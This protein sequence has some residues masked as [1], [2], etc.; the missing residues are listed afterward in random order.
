MLTSL[1]LPWYL[2]CCRRSSGTSHLAPALSHSPSA[3]RRPKGLFGNRASC[4]PAQTLA[5][6]F[7]SFKIRHLL[8]TIACKATCDDLVYPCL[9]FS[10]RIFL[11]C[12][13]HTALRPAPGPLY[14]LTSLSGGG[15]LPCPRCLCPTVP[16][17][18]GLGEL[19]SPPAQA[20]EVCCFSHLSCSSTFW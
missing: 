10:H 7:D 13:E 19:L 16:P 15:W 18:R 9:Y 12:F 17:Q 6:T 20:L 14:L 4:S 11:L 3:H 2:R 8:L 1:H 5:M